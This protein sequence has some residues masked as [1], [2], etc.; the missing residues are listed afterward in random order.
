[1]DGSVPSAA[2]LDRLQE[3]AARV[4]ANV[5][6]VL[7]G[8][9]EL[10]ELAVACLLAEG[11]LLI[12]DVPGVGKTVLAK[13]LAA[14]WGADYSRIQCTPD[15]L[16]ADITGTSVY[17]Q[18]SGRFEFR[19]GPVFAGVVLVDEINRA[20]PKTQSALLEVMEER[21]V[22]VDGRPRA[23][24]RP[25]LVIATQNPVE[26][27]GTYPLPEA[28]LD[29]FMVKTSVGYPPHAEEMD[30]L[31]LRTGRRRE[32][33]PGAVASVGELQA[34]IELVARVYLSAA[35]RDYIVR[36]VAATRGLPQVTLGCSPRAS[37]ALAQAGQARA[38]V[39]GR[40]YVTADDVKALAG[41]V[42]GH[43]M[44]LATQAEL[45]GVTA[46]ALVASV[47]RATAVP[48]ERVPV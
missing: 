34:A 2:E 9:R 36:V 18:G 24:P 19:P 29:R 45:E 1:V 30:V 7:R 43:R 39:A 31:A 26:Y 28:Q 46:A 47:L 40:P 17:H 20:S 33:A 5:G 25:F 32:Q 16:P 37:V 38:A 10:V 8:K 23:V 21:R 44:Q 27:A 41:P 4:A 22:S 35:V 48:D 13:A 42:L 15:L 11:H 12:E 14:S 3:L 6:Q